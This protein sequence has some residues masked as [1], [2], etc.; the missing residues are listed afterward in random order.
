MQ[1]LRRVSGRAIPY[2]AA[3]IDTDVIIPA[4]WL[5]TVTRKGLGR[6]AF[7]TVRAQPS[8]VFDRPEFAGRA[9]PDRG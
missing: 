2:G 1:A 7:E 8:N 4:H 9:D 3:N 6:G 5:K